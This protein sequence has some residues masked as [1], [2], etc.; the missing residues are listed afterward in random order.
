VT[1]VGLRLDPDDDATE[2]TATQI[3][4]LTTRLVETGPG[5]RATRRELERRTAG[6]VHPCPL[7][8][9]QGTVI[10]VA[11][12]RLPD[13]PGPETDVVVVQRLQGHRRRSG[14]VVAVPP[15]P[16]R[17]RS[18]LRFLEQTLGLTRPRLR[19]PEQADR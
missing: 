8:V 1:V 9:I 10:N 11:V 12:E 19:T 6:A 2:V 14:L 15:S 16:L 4:D 17:H 18:L 5:A 3:R 13:G 7:P